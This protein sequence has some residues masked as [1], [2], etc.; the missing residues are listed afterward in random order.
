MLHGYRE[1]ILKFV[2]DRK[3][4][5]KIYF[6]FI[7]PILEYADVVW[8]N[9]TEQQSL[10]LEKIQLEAGRIISGTTKLVGIDK[11]Y[12]ELGCLKLSKRRNLHKLF[13]FFKMENG[14][15]PLF[16]HI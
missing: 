8:D 2:L 11:L 1:L 5:Q 9:C 12:A 16:W 14:Q 6:R 3:Y 13:L 4:L 10:F 7:R 15:A